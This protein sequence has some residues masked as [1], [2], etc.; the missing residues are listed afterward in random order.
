MFGSLMQKS[1]ARSLLRLGNQWKIS[2]T[3]PPRSALALP[4][5]NPRQLKFN[6]RKG[7]LAVGSLDEVQPVSGVL[8]KCAFPISH[9]QVDSRKSV[10]NHLIRSI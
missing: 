9:S 1:A 8:Y 2:K 4:Q 3:R 10:G 5:A 6:F 7:R